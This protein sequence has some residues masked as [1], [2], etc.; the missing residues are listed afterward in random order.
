MPHL[1]IPHWHA[2]AKYPQTVVNSVDAPYTHFMTTTKKSSDSDAATGVNAVKVVNT[3]RA[4]A[5][6]Q[7][8]RKRDAE[9]LKRLAR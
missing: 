2:P 6:L 3:Q 8:I 9:L 5:S 7:K 1:R 4:M